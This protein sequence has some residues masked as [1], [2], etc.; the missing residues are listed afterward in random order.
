VVGKNGRIYGFAGDGDFDPGVGEFGSSVVAASLRSMQLVDYYTPTNWKDINR[1]DLD[2]GSGSPVW[3][4]YKD[5]NLLAG[6]GK[7][8]VVYLM[9]ADLL[10]DKD[11]QTP[12]FVTPRLGNDER[13]FEGKGIWGALSAWRDEEEQ[14]WV[15]V[16]VWGPVSKEA[17]KFSKSNGAVS[18][19]SVMAFKVILDRAAKKPVLEPAWITGDF[20]LP[21]PVVIANGVVFAL[22]TGENARQ[23]QQGG[24]INYSNLTLLT[25]AERRE[26]TQPCALYALDAKTGKVLYE[27][28]S[29]IKG[30]THFSG[31]ALADGCVYAVDHDSRVYCFGLKGK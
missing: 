24:V 28:G 8:G 1:F 6:A 2:M 12:L 5:Y 4:A 14:T 31:L 16:P 20:N 9:D 11:H 25:D 23:T 30:W 3:L 29:A 13:S 26:N 10:G 15:Y 27:S 18:H 21:E 22:S 17:P 7:E 19:G